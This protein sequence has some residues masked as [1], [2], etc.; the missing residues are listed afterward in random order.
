MNFLWLIKSESYK[1]GVIYSTGLNIIAGG[2]QFLNTLIIAFF[3][4]TSIGTDIYFFVI[5][6]TILITTSIINGIDSII[7]IPRAMYLREREGETESR[8]FLNFFIYLYLFIGAIIF[9]II[10]A[11]PVVFYNVFSKF[12][13]GK[14][15]EYRYL[16]YSGSLL[17]FFIIDDLIEMKN[18][19]CR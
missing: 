3:F 14:L 19:S 11:S 9:L 6:V 2:M 8:N 10:V 7:L 18:Y 5:A 16:L 17:I 12:P 13:P 15:T 4:G 1:R